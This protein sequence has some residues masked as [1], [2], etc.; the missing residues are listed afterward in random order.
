MAVTIKKI[1]EYSGVSR[2][3]VDRVLNNRGNVKPETEALVRKIADQ[4]GYTPNIAGK[5]LA[6]R[7]KSL[8]IGII[9]I[10]EGNTFFDDVINGINQAE[11]ELKDY[12]VNIVLKRMKGYN[13]QEQLKLIEELKEN[14]NILI[15]N[16]ISDTAV[17]DAIAELSEKNIGVITVNTDI[18]NSKRLCYVGSDYEKGGET[19]CGMMGFLTNGSA[20]IGILTGSEKIL[21]H[22]QR[23][24]GFRKIMKHKYPNMK[25]I[26]FAATDDDDIQAYEVTK[27]MLSNHKEIDSLF[28]VAAGI[29]GVCRAVMHLKL[30]RKINIISFDKIPVTVDMMKAG[31]IKA[32]ICQQPFTQGNKSVHLAFD[33]LISG[34]KPEKDKYIMKNE[35]KIVENL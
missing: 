32:T 15:L 29:Y 31:I 26:A 2:G 35:I 9:L 4:L 16:A 34:N 5:A 18:E 8:T 13:V 27:Q 33:Y 25:E 19:A 20:N 17:A 12:G 14:M 3:T 6:A 1:A 28:I 24:A 30:E 21:G 10:S 22:K 23:V 11:K 7:K